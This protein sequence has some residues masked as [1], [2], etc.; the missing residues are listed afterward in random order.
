MVWLISIIPLLHWNKRPLLQYLSIQP[1]FKTN[2]IFL[3]PYFTNRIFIYLSNSPWANRTLVNCAYCVTFIFAHTTIIFCTDILP[4]F[5]ITRGLSIGFLLRIVTF[6]LIC[7]IG[8]IHTC[9][10]GLLSF[11]CYGVRILL[12][13][14]LGEYFLSMNCGQHIFIIPPMYPSLVFMCI[15]LVALA[16]SV[17]ILFLGS[18]GDTKITKVGNLACSL[19]WVTL[20]SHC[21]YA[22]GNYPYEWSNQIPNG[23]C[24]TTHIMDILYDIPLLLSF[25]KRH[26]IS[27]LYDHFDNYWTIWSIFL[28]YDLK[29]SLDRLDLYGSSLLS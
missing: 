24:K 19:V 5:Q 27:R 22:S 18:G 20:F 25:S 29:T 2:E 6:L 7:I 4:N 8:M 3:S 17:L 10:S 13:V 15:N 11:R 26:Q 23:S 9:L 21:I 12:F 1:S 28:K 16:T 14:I